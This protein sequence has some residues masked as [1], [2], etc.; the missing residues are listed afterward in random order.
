MTV[1][2]WLTRNLADVIVAIATANAALA[3][4]TVAGQQEGSRDE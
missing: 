4:S 3:E 2:Q 1:S